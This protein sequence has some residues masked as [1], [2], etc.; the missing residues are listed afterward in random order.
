MAIHPDNI[1]LVTHTIKLATVTAS[2]I[3]IIGVKEQE[4]TITTA[5]VR[6]FNNQHIKSSKELSHVKF[7]PRQLKIETQ[8]AYARNHNTFINSINFVFVENLH[9]IDSPIT[10]SDQPNTTLREVLSHLNVGIVNI[11]QSVNKNGKVVYI[12]FTSPSSHNTI[13]NKI[14]EI[15]THNDHIYDNQDLPL[16]IRGNKR[17]IARS[18]KTHLQCTY[19]L[20]L[21][22]YLASLDLHA[23]EMTK[24]STEIVLHL[25]SLTP[26]D[27]FPTTC[28]SSLSKSPSTI[29]ASTIT[30]T[31]S[32]VLPVPDVPTD[33]QPD[34]NAPGIITA[35]AQTEPAISSDTVEHLLNPTQIDQLQQLAN[36]VAQLSLV[37]NTMLQLPAKPKFD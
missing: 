27:A 16:T 15:A 21:Q 13:A 37:I 5:L 26:T 12:A 17:F 14:E 11:Q 1:A 22:Q 25:P 20:E 7:I 32:P 18:T 23:T 29:N 24:P 28:S 19:E 2:V 4:H 34:I 33:V 31:T 36:Q 3:S 8:T 30:A 6:T 10:L 35:E 9:N